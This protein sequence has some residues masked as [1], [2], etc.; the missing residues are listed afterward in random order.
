MARNIDTSGGVS[1]VTYADGESDEFRSVPYARLPVASGADVV[2][3]R[4]GTTGNRVESDPM[5]PALLFGGD[6]N[7]YALWSCRP[8]GPAK[9]PA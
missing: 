3:R 2:G 4:G 8:R 5:K 6:Y 9:N 1:A 7:V